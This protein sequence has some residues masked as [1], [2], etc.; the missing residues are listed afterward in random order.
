MYKKTKLKNN[1]PVILIPQKESQ[2]LTLLVIFKVGSRYEDI[3]IHH[4]VSHFIEHLMFKGTKKR[5]TT[6]DIS[7]ELDGIGAE[8]NAYTAKD[9]TGY[10]IKTNA[11]K[12]GLACDILSDM[13][14]NSLLKQTE[15][16]REK[17]VIIEEIKMYE[18]QPMYYAEMLFEQLVFQG[19]VLGEDIAGTEKSIKKMTRK[20]IIDYMNSFY[21]PGNAVIVVA[22]KINDQTKATLSKYFTQLKKP[23]KQPFK[24]EF[25]LF[26]A[27]QNQPRVLLHY[28]DTKQ[29]HLALGFPAYSYSH[30][31]LY[32]L[33]LLS[34]ILGGNMSSRLFINVR[35]RQGLCY[36]IKSQ[37]DIYEDTGNLMIRSGLD[38]NKIKQAITIIMKELSKMKKQGVTSQELNK[39]KEFIKGRLVL[40]LEESHNLAEFY[41]RQH[42]LRGKLL[43][44]EQKL[45]KIF[46]VTTAQVKKVA[47][48][49]I[50]QEKLSL[51][52]I[53]PY[54]NKNDFIKLLRI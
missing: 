52:M 33:Q 6:L 23:T 35:E 51:A 16:S 5:P 39:A 28:K 48:D 17:G 27:E 30:P 1:F 4:G 49:I 7:Q 14:S 37:A 19:N 54:K 24:Q 10:Y 41:G 15:I 42:I 53:S 47:Q 50:K 43:S 13:L 22:G 34:I 40:Q 36:Y 21:E 11:E 29:V 20:N 18:D 2:S 12:I 46:A 8:F 32:A 31:D 9:H 38:I 26:T 45:N 25:A 3:K 44:P